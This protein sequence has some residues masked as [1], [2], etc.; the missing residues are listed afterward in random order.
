MSL[1]VDPANQM[2]DGSGIV[3]ALHFAKVRLRR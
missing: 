3:S 2:L 1:A